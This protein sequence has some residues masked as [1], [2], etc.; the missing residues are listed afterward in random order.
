[1]SKNSFNRVLILFSFLIISG[2]SFGQPRTFKG[3]VVDASDKDGVFRATI[4]YSVDG[5]AE[6][7]TSD[8]NG[9]FQIT[10]PENIDSLRVSHISY[11]PTMTSI[12]LIKTKSIKIAIEPYA[13]QIKEVIITAKK[14][15]YTNKDNPAV[16]LITKVLENRE[17]NSILN[18]CPL[19]YTAHN[20]TLI[21]L[22]PVNDTVLARMK[23]KPVLN[24]MKDLEPT[25]F[26]SENYLPVYFFEELSQIYCNKGKSLEEQRLALQDIEL[27]AIMDES[28]ARRLKTNIFTKIDLYQKYV[29]VLGNQFMSPVNSFAPQFY[30]FFIEDTLIIEN[31]ECIKLSFIPRNL[32]DIGFMGNLY[33]ANDSSYEIIRAK[34]SITDKANVNFVDKIEFIQKYKTDTFNIDGIKK[35]VSYVVEDA[36]YAK[37][38]FYTLKAYGYSINTYSKPKFEEYVLKDDKEIKNFVLN[39]SNRLSILTKAE[40]KTYQLPDSLDKITWFRVTKYLS[41]IFYGGYLLTG[42]VDIGPLDNLYSFNSIEGNRLR[43]SGKT[44]YK[45]SRRIYADW[46][47][48]YGT[49]DKKMK[50]DLGLKYSFNSLTK[51]PNSFPANFIGLEYTYNTFIP[52]R[53]IE[54]SNYDRLSL[55]ITDIVDYRLAFNKSIFLQW[56]Y[57][58][59]KGITINPYLKFQEVKAY[60]D[61]KFSDRDTMEVGSFR[62]DRIGINIRLLFNGTWI[63]NQNKRISLGGNYTSMNI[64]YEYGF[65][66]THLITASAYRKLNLMPFGYMLFWAEGGY[67][68]GKI[69]SPYLFTSTTYNSII[70]HQNSF[71]LMKVMEFFSDKYVQLIAIYN[72]NGLIFNR[73]PLIRELKLREE[74]NIK[75]VYGS[76]RDENRFMIDNTNVKTFTNKPYI[77]AGFGFQN[78]FQVLGVEYIRRITYT[79]GLANSKKWGIRANL[80]IRF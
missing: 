58:T 28:N 21:A 1:M 78:L 33:I 14:E 79:E 41:E 38:N 18:H 48:A 26:E 67:M 31:R 45:L 74:F 51:N 52:G 56:F 66:I 44:N 23:L 29:D 75:M 69:L 46:M 68:E 9:Y 57:E 64:K 65:D 25:Y 43:F 47:V 60:G 40:R 37:I 10:V 2:F 12:K 61:W 7:V 27:T 72:L 53:T 5:F 77:E 80:Q 20:K 39:D 73:I 59:K 24:L 11:K 63:Q 34:L 76:L 55:S 50:Y 35:Q 6:G 70:Y 13:S 54:N 32:Y 62:K 15:K 17:A 19:N 4:S 30:K 42:P 16:E 36:I 22:D 3:Q 49:K 71:N 8:D